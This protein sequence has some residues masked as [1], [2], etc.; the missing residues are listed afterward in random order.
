[1]PRIFKVG[2]YIIYFWVNEGTPTEP[3]HVHV[4]QVQ[5]SH[6]TKIW[7]TSTHKCLLSNNNS[8]IPPVQLGIIMR[9]IEARVDDIID[10]W[11]KYFG[12][13]TFYC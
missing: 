10:A 2:S 3:I 13:V 1:M 12:E 8:K 9:T 7:I 4:S 11:K 5:S 6:S